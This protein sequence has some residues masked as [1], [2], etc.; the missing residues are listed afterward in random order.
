MK[1]RFPHVPPV[2]APG[3]FALHSGN[4]VPTRTSTAYQPTARRSLGAARPPHLLLALR[5]T[6][7]PHASCHAPALTALTTRLAG[8]LLVRAPLAPQ[9]ADNRQHAPGVCSPSLRWLREP[10]AHTPGSS[11]TSQGV[12]PPPPAPSVAASSCP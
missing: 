5:T 10:P 2:P 6:A 12:V 8:V 11:P 4:H 9:A 3:T 1:P 7:M